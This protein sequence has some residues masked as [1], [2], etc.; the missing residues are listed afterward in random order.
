MSTFYKFQK[1]IFTSIRYFTNEIKKLTGVN[2]RVLFH[3]GLLMESFTTV[4]AGVGS[5]VTVYQHVSG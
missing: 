5:S 4:G 3:V 1:V 2:I